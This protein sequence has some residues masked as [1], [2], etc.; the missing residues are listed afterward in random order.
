MQ[1]VIL[2]YFRVNYLNNTIN[3]LLMVEVLVILSNFLV[4]YLFKKVLLQFFYI[5][6]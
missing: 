2:F 1:K 3:C 4:R 5:T 6:G